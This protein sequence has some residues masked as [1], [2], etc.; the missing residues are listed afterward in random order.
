[1]P[2]K[3]TFPAYKPPQLPLMAA[4][5]YNSLCI[6][7]SPWSFPAGAAVCEAELTPD[8]PVFPT[9]CA[10]TVTLDGAPCIIELSGTDF[11][12]CHSALCSEKDAQKT[13]IEESVLPE[14]V[15]EAIFHS[16]LHAALHRMEE[17]TKI[18]TV[19]TGLFFSQMP[20]HA[21]APS[22]GFSLTF[23]LDN[24][25]QQT[26]LARVIFPDAT[27][28]PAL[29]AKL[30]VLPVRRNGFLAETLK[31]VSTELGF[32]AGYVRISPGDLAGLEPDDILVPDEWT[33]PT[34]I[35]AV[36]WH[37]NGRRI[38][39]ECSCAKN[40][41]TLTTP[42]AE[43]SIM[44]NAEHKDLE[45]LL[46]F[47]L[48]RRPIA[49]SDLEEIVPGHAFPLSAGLDAPV[50][51]RANGKAIAQGRIVDMGGTLGIQILQKL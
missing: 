6:R 7:Q 21:Y 13:G 42:L 43:D 2:E 29:S 50:T 39:G 5:L 15:R 20:R 36:I 8:L 38:A 44:E 35:K 26:L 51:I 1:M 41:A 9:A 11:L 16:L 14:E 12:N 45:L 28:I 24:A 22:I 34:S 27:R 37:G 17:E 3:A 30:R 23:S 18:H 47:E 48:D 31:G 33:L 25:F 40:D 32:E 4:Q 19:I 46:S 10:A 49:L